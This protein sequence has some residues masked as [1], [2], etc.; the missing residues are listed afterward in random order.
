VTFHMKHSVIQWGMRVPLWLEVTG[1]GPAVRWDVAGGESRSEGGADGGGSR[2][3]RNGSG[4]DRVGR[5]SPYSFTLG[6]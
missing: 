1:V 6:Q 2:A 4:A 5:G 3:D